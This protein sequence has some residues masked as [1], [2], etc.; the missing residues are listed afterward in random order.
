MFISVPLVMFFCSSWSRRDEQSSRPRRG[1]CRIEVGLGVPITTAA[2]M[3]WP[4]LY[5]RVKLS[6][7]EALGLSPKDS[8][9][10]DISS[11]EKLQAL[12]ERPRR[13]PG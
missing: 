9:R 11:P 10:L 7:G 8:R 2:I 13:D 6:A 12:L 3:S 4:Y 5:W 1:V